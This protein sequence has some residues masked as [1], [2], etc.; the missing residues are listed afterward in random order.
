[1]PT[2]NPIDIER[3][4][5]AVLAEVDRVWNELRDVP[6][7]GRMTDETTTIEVTRRA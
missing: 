7:G 4:D 5:E 6:V 3:P 1:V 2:A